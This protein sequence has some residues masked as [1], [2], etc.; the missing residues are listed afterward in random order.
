MTLRGIISPL[1]AWMLLR[2]LRTL[3][4]RVKQSSESCVRVVEYL[5]QHKGVAKIHWP[6]LE[7]HPNK[8]W[9]ER[10]MPV[11]VPMFSMQLATEDVKQ[12]EAFVDALGYFLIGASWGGHESLV[13][14]VC[15][16]YES[17]LPVNLLRMYVGLEEAEELIADLEG[18][19]T[20]AGL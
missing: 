10:Q 6:F 18:A 7:D 20:A 9:V 19:F 12:V 8:G 13:L 1:S 3:P 14:P 2:S 16:F 5:Q 11:P 4:V 17:D 15:G